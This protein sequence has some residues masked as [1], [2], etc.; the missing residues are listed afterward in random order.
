ML[1]IGSKIVTT[2][3]SLQSLPV[4]FDDAIYYLPHTLTVQ[5]TALDTCITLEGKCVGSSD[6]HKLRHAWAPT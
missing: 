5:T 3:E 2:E 1:V 4:I 6:S